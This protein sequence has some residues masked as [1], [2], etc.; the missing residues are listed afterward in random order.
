MLTYVPMFSST[1][2]LFSPLLTVCINLSAKIDPVT[3][4][5]TVDCIIN[6]DCHPKQPNSVSLSGDGAPSDTVST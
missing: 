2:S 1:A 5:K 6:S 4:F 3:L